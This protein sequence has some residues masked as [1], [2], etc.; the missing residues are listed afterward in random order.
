MEDH[1][2]DRPEMQVQQCIQ[3]TGTNRPTGL[4]PIQW[5]TGPR[6]ARGPDPAGSHSTR[7]SVL[8]MEKTLS[9][10]A[11]RRSPGRRAFCRFGGES[12]SET[13]DPIPNSAVKRRR[14]DGTASQDAGE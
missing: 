6:I 12:A 10:R 8:D 9:W 11:T 7:T 1:H 5:K 13:P 14:A 3:L 4:I 2:V